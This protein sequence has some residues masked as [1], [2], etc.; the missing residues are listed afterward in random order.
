MTV[1]TIHAGP[2]IPDIPVADIVRIQGKGSY[3]RIFFADNRWPVTVPKVL[4]Q[5]EA[6][7]PHSMFVR[8][9]RAHLINKSHIVG[10]RINSCPGHIRLCNGETIAVS[11]R[12]RATLKATQMAD[13]QLL[14]GSFGT[15]DPTRPM[16]NTVSV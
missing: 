5:F 9:H 2:G 6:L 4:K 10:L 13:G 8:V 11:R 16:A 3:S 14:H 1:H 15:H 7:L 12:R